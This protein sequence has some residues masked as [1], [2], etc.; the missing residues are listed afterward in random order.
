[1]S[2]SERVRCGSRHPLHEIAALQRRT[3][4]ARCY[5]R[6]YRIR[7]P[8][9]TGRQAMSSPPC[10]KRAEE[11]G[12]QRGVLARD[13]GGAGPA[14]VQW[15]G[16]HTPQCGH[17]ETHT[18]REP[19]GLSESKIVRKAGSTSA[20]CKA[21]Q[22]GGG[23]VE[24]AQ[25]TMWEVAMANLSARRA[26]GRHDSAIGLYYVYT[27]AVCQFIKSARRCQSM[28]YCE[29]EAGEGKEMGDAIGYN[30]SAAKPRI[31]LVCQATC[32]LLSST[33]KTRGRPIAIHRTR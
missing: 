8:S 15:L 24:A 21:G 13:R 18:P 14:G 22:M 31:K 27:C 5:M 28:S 23:L 4:R 30:T 19:L 9:G 10:T 7:S 20:E 11:R 32:V 17:R 2:K 1:M 16:R 25:A 26:S 33:R 29:R 12:R 6:P 3:R